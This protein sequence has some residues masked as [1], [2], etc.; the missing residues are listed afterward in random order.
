MKEVEGVGAG[1]IADE[2]VEGLAVLGRGQRP[3]LDLDAMTRAAEVLRGTHD[4]RAFRSSDDTRENTTRTLHRIALQPRWGGDPDLLAL[5]VTGD[6]FM[7]NMVRILAGTLIEVGHGRF[8]V[9]H[10]ATLLGSDGDRRS[11]GMTAPAPDSLRHGLQEAAVAMTTHIAQGHTHSYLRDFLRCLDASLAALSDLETRVLLARELQLIP[12]ARAA[13]FE[14]RIA[15]VRRM[16]WGLVNRLRARDG[17]NG[18][19]S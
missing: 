16:E 15:E 10:V 4:F 2:E 12:E 18:V 17:G 13:V 6:A 14:E 1:Q 5:E 3:R 7:K 8:T 11:A 19:Q 9:E